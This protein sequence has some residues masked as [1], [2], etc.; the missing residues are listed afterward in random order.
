MS[1]FDAL[2]EQWHPNVDHYRSGGI[3]HV[4]GDETKSVVGM[5]PTRMMAQL[6]HHDGMWT[7]Q[8]SGGTSRD[9][10]TIDS[11]KSDITSGKGIHT[12]LMI[13]YNPDQKRGYL[14]EGNHRLRAAEEAGAPVVPAR[15]VRSYKDMSKLG[16]PMH[17]DTVFAAHD[18]TYVPSDIHPSHFFH[19]RRESS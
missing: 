17:T 4:E 16:A 15:V 11:I 12:P 7:G 10:E 8:G 2:G 1:A 9:R 5:V 19:D 6:R 3:G 13:E 18:S 14:G